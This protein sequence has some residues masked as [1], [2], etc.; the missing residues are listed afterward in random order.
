MNTPQTEIEYKFLNID[1]EDLKKKLEQNNA[2]FIFDTV[3]KIYNHDKEEWRPIQGRV[4]LREGNGKA[5]M[6]YKEQQENGFDK[7]IEF[8]IAD[9]E[10]AHEL[11][12]AINIPVKRVEQKRRIR[13][14]LDNVEIDIDFWPGIEPYIEVE[15]ET[16]EE[17]VKVATLLGFDIADGVKM[18][19]AQVYKMLTGKR[20]PSEWVFDRK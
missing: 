20:V 17:I 9:I 19:A 7:E 11:L 18:N 16:E 5:T 15:A 12:N 13:Y 2:K 1:V 10:K 4:R 6:A 3:Y 14:E 8:E